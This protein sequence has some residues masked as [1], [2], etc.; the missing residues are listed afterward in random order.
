MYLALTVF[1][2][3]ACTILDRVVHLEDGQYWLTEAAKMIGRPV[4]EGDTVMGV[5]VDRIGSEVYEG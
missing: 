4:K 1:A 2:D 5:R 3:E